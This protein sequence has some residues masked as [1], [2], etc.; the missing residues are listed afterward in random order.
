[1][2]W[3]RKNIGFRLICSSPS[4]IFSR[5]CTKWFPSLSF[6]TKCSEWENI[7]FS[8]V[9][10]SPST[11]FSRPCTKWFPFFRSFAV[12]QKTISQ[13]LVKILVENFLKPGEFYLIE[14][15]KLPDKWQEVMENNSEYTNDWNLFIDNLIMNKLYFTKRIIYDSSQYFSSRFIVQDN[16]QMTEPFAISEKFIA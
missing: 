9:C 13:D 6:S 8:L 12:N 4:T 11:I 16:D 10:S 15:N 2:L 3:M 7:G 5:P 14:I 1:M